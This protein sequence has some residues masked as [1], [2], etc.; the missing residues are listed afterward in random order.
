MGRFRSLVGGWFWGRTFSS[1]IPTT[2]MAEPAVRRFINES[3]TGSP[4]VWPMAWLQGLVGA[5]RLGRCVV[6]GCGDGRLGRD[7]ARKGLGRQILGIDLSRRAIERARAQARAEGL[8]GLAYR[9]ADLNRLRLDRA[10]FDGAFFHQA[11]HHVESLE[12]CLGT[13][14]DALVDGGLFYVDEYVGPSRS[15]WHP[16]LLAEADALYRSLPPEVRR[17]PHLELPVDWRDPTEAI[18]SSEILPVVRSLF[19]VVEE[20][21]YGGNFLSV[22]YPHLR[23][24]ALGGAGRR[25][26]VLDRI[27]EAERD[28]LAHLEGGAPSYYTVLVCRPRL[29]SRVQAF[30]RS[31]A[32]AAE[33]QEA[34]REVRALAGDPESFLR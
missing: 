34:D 17:R 5:E 11:L 19:D 30:P 22:I 8:D 15:E 20:R 23:L 14:R 24:D 18:R 3:V 31:T 33:R 1:G 21:P 32:G 2:W 7:L 4:D 25:E 6:L 13:V 26:A 12:H 29:E 10:S 28:Q 9:R 27:I 16:D